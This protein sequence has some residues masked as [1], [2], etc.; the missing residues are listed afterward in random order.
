MYSQRSLHYILLYFAFNYCNLV[1]AQTLF[2]NYDLHFD[3]EEVATCN[4]LYD[5][6]FIATWSTN[7][8]IADTIIR[9]EL[10]CFDNFGEIVWKKFI[11][12][13][14]EDIVGWRSNAPRDMVISKD[15]SIYILV[16]S[17]F[18]PPTLQAAVNKFDINGNFHW[19]RTY[20][21]PTLDIYPAFHGLTLESDSINI[22]FTGILDW[23]GENERIIIFRI[24]TSGNIVQEIIIDS[25]EDKIS[26]FIPVVSMSDNALY[27][28]HSYRT[29]EFDP[30]NRHYMIRA[31][32]YGVFEEYQMDPLRGY[33]RDLKLHP[34]GNL[35]Y[36]SMYL[37]S[38]D[39]HG[40]VNGWDGGMMIYM[41][42]P[43]MDTVWTHYFQDLDEW[44]LNFFTCQNYLWN[45]TISPDGRILA[46]GSLGNTGHIV[47][48]DENGNFMWKRIYR[49]DE[50]PITGGE[51]QSISWTSDGGIAVAGRLSWESA[52]QD[53]KWYQC[54]GIFLLKLDGDG[55]L[56]PDCNVV[57]YLTTSIE[58]PTYFVDE[59]KVYPNPAV[60]NIR[61]K[62][63]GDRSHLWNDAYISILDIQ[64]HEKIRSALKL[65]ET[66]FDISQLPIGIY[67]IKITDQNGNI[68]TLKFVK[69]D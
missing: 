16:W 23:D 22:A 58:E 2:R 21:H 30:A 53:C 46:L 24:D 66:Y 54:R 37:G 39:Q 48:L 56:E 65:P 3:I 7:E 4:S 49:I 27:M 51:F 31:D 19:M 6:V 5:K 25:A 40:M 12:Y 33:A 64:G 41:L 44:P 26:H 20:G 36:L 69:T 52:N 1:W 59:F 63:H 67:C 13:P 55:C 17:N 18:H 29:W 68:N 62:Y 35:V 60:E 50:Y 43:E 42:T 47:C 14:N 9:D 28:A 45:L 8:H 61:I 15:S 34:N 10:I 38:L 57:N 11:Q 32:T